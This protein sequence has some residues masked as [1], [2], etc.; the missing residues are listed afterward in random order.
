MLVVLMLFPI[1]MAEIRF[2]SPLTS[3]LNLALGTFIGNVI[4]VVLLGWPLMPLGI[5]PFKWWLLPA[6]DGAWWIRPAGIAV[7]MALYAV[8]ITALWHF[9]S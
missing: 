2:L 5:R 8:E 4:S 3:G 6:Q 7:V 1:V 9:V